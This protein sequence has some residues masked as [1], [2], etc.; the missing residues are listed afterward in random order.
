MRIATN[1]MK[2]NSIVIP[3]EQGLRPTASAALHPFRDSIVIPLEQ[4]LRQISV[5]S[6]TVIDVLSSFH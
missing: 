3:L 1:T 6:H 5:Y 4:G 2:N